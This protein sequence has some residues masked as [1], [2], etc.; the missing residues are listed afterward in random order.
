VS[1]RLLIEFE[2]D[3]AG[4]SRLERAL[5]GSE[6]K[7]PV[8]ILMNP[9]Y[10]ENVT[11]ELATSPETRDLALAKLAASAPESQIKCERIEIVR[12]PA[13]S[14]IVVDDRNDDRNY[15]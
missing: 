8:A 2:A 5:V 15:D 13:Q 7:S 12:V 4:Y 9:K 11:A 10:R 14:I 3:Y 6:Q 1:E